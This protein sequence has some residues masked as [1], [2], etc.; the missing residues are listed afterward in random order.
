MSETTTVTAARRA[1][2]RSWRRSTPGSTTRPPS[3]AI[4]WA[5]ER[6]GRDLVLAASFQ[7]VVLDRPGRQVDPGIEVVFFDTGAHFPETLAFVEEVRARYDLNLT[8]THPGPEA[9][10]WP[11]GSARCCEFR[12]VAPLRRALAGK[13]AWLTALKRV[14]APTRAAAPVVGWD[15]AFGL[16]KVN[17]LATWTDD[18]IDSY[19]ADHGLPVHP[20]VPPGLP[21]DRLR[22]DHPP[23]RPRARTRGRGAGRAPAR[24]SAGCTPEPCPATS[25]TPTACEFRGRERGHAV[26]PPVPPHRRAQPGR[27]AGSSH[28]HPFEVAQA[29]IDRYS[30][31]GVGAINAVPGEVERLKWVGLYPQ[32]QGGDAFM[33]RIKVPGG[34]LTAAQAREIGIAADA[35]GEGPDDSPVFGNRYADITTRQTIQLHWLRIEDIPRIWQ[36]FWEV[37][38]TTVQACGDS[39]PQ[40][41]LLPGVGGRRRRG[42]RGPA[43]GPGHLGLLHRQPRV[44]QPAPQVQDRGHRLPRGL[45]PGRDR[46]HRPV[47]GPGRRRHGRLQRAGRR[48]PLRRR[49]HGLGHRRLRPARPGGRADPGHRPDL[50]RA[51]QPREP[52]PGP[53]ALPGPGARPRGVPGGAGRADPLRA[54]AGRRGADPALPRRP[55]GRPPP[56]AG[57]PGLRRAARC[58]SAGC[59]ASSWS[60]RPGWPRPTATA[61]CGS[62]TDQNFILS[63]VPEDRLDDLLAEP[64]IRQ[65]SPFPGPFTRGVVACTGS[66]FCRFAVVE[67]KERAVKW[68]RFL[69]ERPRPRRPPGRRPTPGRRDAGPTAPARTRVIR[70]HFSGCSA[71]CA[72]PQIADIGFRG[73]IAHVGEHIEEA[74]DIGLGG[75]LGPDAAFIDWVVGAMPVDQVPEALVRVVRR[76]QAERRDGRA[77]P[78][79]GPA[80][81]ER[82]AA[83]HPGAPEG[84]VVK[85]YR[86]R[87]EMN[88]IAEPPGKVWFWELEAGV[89]DADRCIQCGTC[90]AV[91]PS[92][93]IGVDEDTDLPELVKMCTGC[94]LCWDF[95]PAAACATRRCG[96]RRRADDEPT[97]VV[98]RGPVG[99]LGHL[100]EDHRRPAGRR[101]RGGPRAATPCGP[102]PSPTTSRT[103][104]RSRP[105]WSPCWPPGEIDGALVSKPSSDPDEPWKGVATIATT[106]AEIA[107]ASGSFYNQTMAL[108]ELDLSRYELPAKPRLAVVGTPCEIQGIRAM[109]A[110]RWPTGAHRV[111]AVVLDHRPACAPRAST[112]RG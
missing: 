74:V 22:P 77:V 31:E 72:Q 46:R 53:H 59:T 65:Y 94:S 96:R 17:P 42:G 109:Q 54:G 19:L 82:G 84:G 105:S 108:A 8:V 71:S 9:D 69:D 91:C 24:P 5:V 63:G 44:R 60:R 73:D 12:K 33:M 7:D 40:R 97:P 39:R 75:S 92:N 85:R 16:V 36:R 57:G 111:D 79:L 81:P 25:T 88:G 112:T 14:D 103:A 49:A 10:A 83:R 61:P 87:E 4:E 38:L 68:A 26:R 90:V 66:E 62:G 47:A 106:P 15:D 89:I 32:R 13:P 52:G 45:R 23:G 58:R 64:L 99:L 37:G 43:G 28:R 2:S 29:V 50:R 21:L 110:R 35:F 100:L 1:W 102:R 78:H 18:D 93:S 6:F 95:C 98:H 70:M 76:Y 51:R 107:A 86:L 48:R 55:R 41:L 34:V 11:C 56:E 3:K 30:K 27:A 101:A 104:G 80:D 67:T 20:L